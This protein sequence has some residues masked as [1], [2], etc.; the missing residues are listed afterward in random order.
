MH[1]IIK[2]KSGY[3]LVMPHTDI[4]LSSHEAFNKTSQYL[5]YF[6]GD[7]NHGWNLSKEEY[8]RIKGVLK[9]LNGDLLKEIELKIIDENIKKE[10]HEVANALLR[11]EVQ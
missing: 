10:F 4:Y 7:I 5:V 8:N 1:I 11:M 2:T 9:L 3:E 6:I